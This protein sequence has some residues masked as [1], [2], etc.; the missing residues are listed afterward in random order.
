MAGGRQGKIPT[1]AFEVYDFTTKK[2]STLSDIPSKRVF[3]MYAAS[4]SHIHSVGGLLQPA[5]QGFSDACEVY[6][7]QEGEVV[8]FKN[9]NMTCCHNCHNNCC[10]SLQVARATTVIFLLY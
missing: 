1:A 7:L 2:W 3:A 6:S 9:V 4:D 5:N 8:Q 10:N